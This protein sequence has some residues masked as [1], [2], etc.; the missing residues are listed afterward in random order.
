MDQKKTLCILTD[1]M[2]VGG[3]EKVLIEAL[4]VLHSENL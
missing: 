2:I 4:N 3:V 1:Y